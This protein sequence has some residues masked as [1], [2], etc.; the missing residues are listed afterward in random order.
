MAALSVHQRSGRREEVEAGAM[1]FCFE[2]GA[3][4]L[5][6]GDAAGDHERAAGRV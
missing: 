3:Q 5:V 1:R 6:G 2:A 4:R